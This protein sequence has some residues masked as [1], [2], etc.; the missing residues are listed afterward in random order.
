MK[1][2]RPKIYKKGPDVMSK[3][4]RTQ[5]RYRVQW[6]TQTSLDAFG[7]MR[8]DSASAADSDMEFHGAHD[9]EPKSC[10]DMNHVFRGARR[11]SMLSTSESG[12]FDSDSDMAEEQV[13]NRTGQS[14]DSDEHGSA[15]AHGAHLD[16]MDKLRA[17][18]DLRDLPEATESG[19]DGEALT[20]AGDEGETVGEDWEDE[21]EDTFQGA[22]AVI[23]DWKTLREQINTDLKNKHKTLPL[24]QINQ[25]MIL[26]NFAN[27]RLKGF[28][29]I[30]ASLEIARQWREGTGT[31]FAR[32]IRALARHYQVFEQL[33]QEKRG[34]KLNA[35]SF[36]HDESV[37]ARCRTWLSNIS[38]GQVTPQ[39]LQHAI[40]T[41][42]F[43]ELGIVPKRPIS[44]RTARRWLV[45]L[46]WRQMVIRKG[47]YMDGHERDDV[48]KYRNEVYLPAMQAFEQRMVQFEGPE[49]VRVEPTLKPGER[50]IK[51]YYHDE[52]CFHAN[53]NTNSAWYV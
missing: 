40:E 14:D 46:G 49:L 29:R 7:F 9:Q 15:F 2:A 39:K 41:T 30:S 23:K 12:D 51:P 5:R 25:L 8:M 52:C 20:Q 42:I 22:A 18:S 32:R 34:G 6:R 38:S 37:Q 26:S 28:S 48:V 13:M 50:R 44:L 27:L 16:V 43:P 33:P 53:D 4:E 24:S 36:L 3:S 45:K 35:Y 11:A 47:V 19:S 1:S 10:Q 31:W 17:Q 21:L